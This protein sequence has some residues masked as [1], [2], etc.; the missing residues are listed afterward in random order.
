MC[1][2]QIFHG[3]IFF[4]SYT[5]LAAM[6]LVRVPITNDSARLEVPCCFLDFV[7]H[8]VQK[9]P[10]WRPLDTRTEISRSFPE[11]TASTDLSK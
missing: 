11:I 1:P 7:G 5:L 2:A 6:R 10:K 4:A 8:V 9:P 3:H